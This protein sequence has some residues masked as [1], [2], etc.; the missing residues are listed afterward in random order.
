MLFPAQI[1]SDQEKENEGPLIRNDKKLKQLSQYCWDSKILQVMINLGQTNYSI[2]NHVQRSSTISLSFSVSVIHC[3]QNNLDLT[4]I[5]ER[6]LTQQKSGFKRKPMH[7]WWIKCGN[8]RKPHTTNNCNFHY[9][10]AVEQNRS[11]GLIEKSIVLARRYTSSDPYIHVENTGRIVVTI[12]QDHDGMENNS[13]QRFNCKM[14]HMR[15]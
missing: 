6:G 13:L 1:L 4:K 12:L 7:K 5:Y 2:E 11:C 14:A 9:I 3:H 8:R 15:V 10:F